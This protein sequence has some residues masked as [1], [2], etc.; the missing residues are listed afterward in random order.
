MQFPANCTNP[1]LPGIFKQSPAP[2]RTNW[3]LLVFFFIY[4]ASMDQEQFDPEE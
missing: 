3:V 1:E 2:N 4:H